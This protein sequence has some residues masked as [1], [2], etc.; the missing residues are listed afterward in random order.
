M[1]YSEECFSQD[2][3]TDYQVWNEEK[4]KL[5]YAYIKTRNLEKYHFS[6]KDNKAYDYPY[7]AFF[8]LFGHSEGSFPKY[9]CTKNITLQ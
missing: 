4:S 6:H 9:V 1:N 7:K 3:V 5:P 8:L 2:I